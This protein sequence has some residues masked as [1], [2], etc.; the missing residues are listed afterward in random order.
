MQDTTKLSQIVDVKVWSPEQEAKVTA[1]KP[2]FTDLTK[3]IIW[4]M[5]PR[6]CQV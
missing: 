5:Q 4:G 3:A 1:S 2:L 6:A